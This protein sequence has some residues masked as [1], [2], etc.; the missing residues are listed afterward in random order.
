ML[1]KRNRISAR[2]AF[3]WFALVL[4]SFAW[5]GISEPSEKTEEIKRIHF[6]HGASTAQV[7]GAVVRGERALYSIEAREGQ[8]MSLRIVALEKNAVVQVYAPGAKQEMRNSVLHIS[9]DTLPGA[10]EGDD[11]ARWSGTLPGSG[12]YVLVVGSTRGN[13]TYRLTV[14]LR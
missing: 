9:G 8:H 2:T 3:A 12:V 7:R 13:A 4:T 11:A 14:T 10:G 6:A 1:A 5:P